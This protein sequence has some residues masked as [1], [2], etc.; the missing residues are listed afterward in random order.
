MPQTAKPDDS[1]IGDLQQAWAEP[2]VTGLAMADGRHLDLPGVMNL[3]DL[4]GYPVAG[5]GSIRW[6]TLLR[7]DALN[8]LDGTSLAALAGL[9]LRTIVDL[10]TD[11][12]VEV[13]PSAVAGLAAATTHI[14]LLSGDLQALPL[15]LAAIYQYMIDEC[16]GAIAAAVRVLCRAAALP[17]LLHCSAGKDRTGIVTAL[18]LAVAGVPDEYIAADYALSS[19]YLDPQRTAAIGHL[20][21]STGLGDRLTAS[22]LASPPALILEVLARVRSTAGSA[23]RYLIGHGLSAAELATLRAALVS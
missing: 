16:G 2:Q 6:R 14:S 23:D 18:V 13:A 9:D 8:R 7:S 3:R 5:G 19:V 10:R 22:L 11:A 15:E 17:A 1:R 20:Q 12:E 4:G 21:A